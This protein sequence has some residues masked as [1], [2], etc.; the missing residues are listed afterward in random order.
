MNAYTIRAVAP[1]EAAI[2]ALHRLRMFQDMGEVPDDCA[3]PL[4]AASETALRAL[5]ASG[6]YR[7]WFARD[8]TSRVIAGAGAHIKPHLPRMVPGRHRVACEAVPLVVN[9]Y[10]EPAWRGRGVARALMQRLMDWAQAEGY[11]RV[12]LHA[13]DAGR[14]L[15][16]GL[17]FVATNEMR[18]NPRG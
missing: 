12:V 15:Y 4:R 18:W 8:G 2:V 5:F 3:E 1:D 10:T 13:S 11:D 17:G 7:G 14:G 6:E 9:V 16:E